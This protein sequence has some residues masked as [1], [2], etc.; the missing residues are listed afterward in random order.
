[1]VSSDNKFAVILPMPMEVNFLILISVGRLLLTHFANWDTIWDSDHFKNGF[2]NKDDV[3][4]GY[5]SERFE[6]VLQ[7]IIEKAI[8]EINHSK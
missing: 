7:N 4:Q 2:P 1:M 8:N 5:L 6:Y 3:E